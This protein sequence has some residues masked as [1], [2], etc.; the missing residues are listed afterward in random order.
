MA[1]VSTAGKRAADY[2]DIRP[3]ID[4]CKTAKVFAVQEWI[5]SGK[6]VNPPP[7]PAKGRRS[8][9]PLEVA[10]ERGIHSLA[11]VLL[12]G[13]A[14]LEPEGWNSPMNQVLAARRL[15]L[16]E[17]LVENGD[18][19][20]NV[21]MRRVVDTWDP[22]I[23]G[24][25]IE[26]GCN[27]E[28]TKPFAYAFCNRIRTA[29]GVFK[30]CREYRPSLQEQANVALRHHCK[31]GNLKWGSLMLWLGADPCK[32]GADHYDQEFG[33]NDSGLSAIGFAALYGK[34]EIFRLK[35][36][37]LDVSSP[38][39]R[40]SLH[41]L[42]QG[43]GIDILQWLLEKGA[44]PNDQENGGSSA[45]QRWLNAM[46]WSYSFDPWSREN[47]R[48]NLDTAEARE[49]MKAIHLLAKHGGRWAPID[50]NEIGSARRSLLK[51]KP[52][53]SVEFIWIMAKYG[54]SAAECLE[55][56]VS[57]PSMRAH[58]KGHLPRIQE[59][60]SSLRK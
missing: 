40:D 48:K 10:I 4:L 42:C 3:L 35:Q 30:Q 26:R 54:A 49:R 50:R 15:D 20:Q 46:S 6:P 36:L 16:V 5:A 58:V 25:F 47:H 53:Y 34:F 55:G 52:D 37:R 12:K 44:A 38:G 32:P 51:L 13:G 8:K 57:T 29:I 1:D 33:D 7:I 31:E 11:D 14:I 17:L 22:T 39:V 23:M 56:L 41:Y 43:E 21:D 18:D 19:P 60:I 27:L 45:I 28:L 2:D 9:T 59:L 24:Y